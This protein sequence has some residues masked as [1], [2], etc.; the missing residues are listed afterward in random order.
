MHHIRLI[1]LHGL[2]AG[3]RR[4]RIE[5]PTTCFSGLCYDHRRGH[6]YRTSCWG[7]LYRSLCQGYLCCGCPHSWR[8]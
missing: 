3:A 8:L 2:G 5:S 1:P 6:L 4:T 7:C